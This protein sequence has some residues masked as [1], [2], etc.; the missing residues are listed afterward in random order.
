MLLS[1]HYCYCTI[2]IVYDSKL[3]SIKA[4]SLNIIFVIDV[5]LVSEEQQLRIV[6]VSSRP[7]PRFSATTD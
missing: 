4:L 5:T 6:R 2:C 1:G 7:P 3:L